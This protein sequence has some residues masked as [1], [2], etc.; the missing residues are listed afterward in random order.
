MR[1]ITPINLYKKGQIASMD[2]L[3]ALFGFLLILVF[4]ISLWTLYLNRL[5]DSV[6]TRRLQLS[7]F[8]AVDTLL[9]STGTPVDWENNPNTSEVIGLASPFG[10]I[11]QKK[12]SAFMSLGYNSTVTLLKI[13]SFY[14]NFSIFNLNGTLLN[15]TGLKQNGTEQVVSVNRLVMIKNETKRISFVL[16]EK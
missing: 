8:Q 7:A 13:K 11:D 4:I 2:I 6:A 1:K 14:Y 10:S 5:D 12:L 16:W 3:A 15:S 9:R